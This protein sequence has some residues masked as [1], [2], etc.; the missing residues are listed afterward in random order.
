MKLFLVRHG[1]TEANL[2]RIYSG[3]RDVMLTDNGRAQAVA[4]RPVLANMKFDRVYSSDLTR[5]IETQRLALPGVEGVRTPLLREIDAG[6]AGGCPFGQVPG[7]PE[8]WNS[9]KDPDPYV[10]VGGESFAQLTERLRCFLKQLEEDPCDRVAVFAHNGIIGS[11]MR[12]VLGDQL[13]RRAFVADNCSIHVFE[14]DGTGWK[15]LAWNYMR[16]F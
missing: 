2:N 3:Q 16:E 6:R 15:I 8:G 9:R 4:I 13:D 5:A 1:Q 7:A 11:M 10:K 14:F 12:I